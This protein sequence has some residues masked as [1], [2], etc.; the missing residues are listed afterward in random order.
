MNC[1]SIILY[2][3][4]AALFA[5]SSLSAEDKIYVNKDIERLPLGKS[6]YYLEDP[7]RKLTFEDISKPDIESKFIKSDKDSLDFGQLNYNYWF[8][9]TFENDTPESVSK[10]VEINYSNIDIVQFYKPNS[11]GTYSKEESGML[12]PFSARSFKNRNF[13]YQIDL[14][15]GQQK[16]YYLMTWTSG[17]LNIPLTLWDKDTFSQYNADVQHGLGLYY[18]VMIVMILYNIFIFFSVR[19]V[20][21]F[22][23]VCYILGF[24]GIQL[25]LTGHGFQYLWP[26]FPFLQRNFYVVFTGISIASVLLFTKRFLNTKE[27][28]P[29]WLDKSMKVTVVAHGL[30]LFTPLVLPP[31]VTVKLALVLTL[32]ALILIPTA[33]IISFLKK[34]RPARYFLLAFTVLTVSGTV[35]VLR[36]INVLG[37][38]FLADYGLY[39]GSTMEVILLSIALADRINIMKKEKEEAQAKTLEM[40]KILTESYARFVPKDFLANLGK[41]SILDVRLGDQIQ[42]EMAVLFSDIRSFTTL[43]EQMTPAENFNFINSYLSRM[44]PIIQRHNGFIDKFIGDAIMALFQRNVI[45]AVSAGV[46]MQRYLKEYN[47]HRHRQGYIPIQIGVG[48]HSGSL[49]LGTIGAEE[50]LEGTVISDTVNLASRIESLTKVY[51]S[52]IAVSESTIEEV[53]KDGKFHFRFLDRV[54]VKGK[55]RP[56]SVYEVFDGDEP[57]Y[58]D[59]K[60]KTKESYEKG[61]KAFYSNSFE[62]AKQQFENV[63]SIFP[64]DKA[65]QLYLKRLYPVTHERK[66]EEVEE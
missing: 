39:L 57:Q 16:T 31:E 5:S 43:S 11:D 66:L 46:E 36:F 19:D 17:G 9:L 58:Q 24:L 14:Q 54:K 44:S 47:E 51:G 42:K 26:A 23:Y 7:E 18:G 56:V 30:L 25:V 32:P 48:I 12:F 15:P 29:K 59:L 22:Y 2:I 55:Q 65:T 53:K 63:I 52:R 1:K 41:D 64:D 62:D 60:L 10:L 20:S 35:V 33:T 3:I 37:P 6:V 34:F 45:D 4:S 61:V 13:V 49:M 27:N 21:Y 50:R 28:V 8:R 40:Q 38:G